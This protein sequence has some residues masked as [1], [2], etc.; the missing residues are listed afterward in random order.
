MFSKRIILDVRRKIEIKRYKD[1]ADQVVNILQANIRRSETTQCRP[2]SSFLLGG[3]SRIGKGLIAQKLANFGYASVEMD[4]VRRLYHDPLLGGYRA[5][6]NASKFRDFFYSYAVGQLSGVVFEGTD[7][8]FFL[9]EKVASSVPKDIRFVLVG[10]D[11]CQADI[12]S[13]QLLESSLQGCRRAP[14]SYEWC[15]SHAQKTVQISREMKKISLE[16]KNVH[17]H[18]FD[19]SDGVF[20]GAEKAAR[21]IVDDLHGTM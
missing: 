14:K 15:A 18:D 12:K 21:Y 3:P 9:K 11:E 2:E 6:K 5:V 1:A 19:L 4:E 13:K 17:Y 16:N 20:S 7:V 10:I 8:W